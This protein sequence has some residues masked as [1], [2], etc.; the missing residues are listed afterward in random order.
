MMR[1]EW[2]Q[3]ALDEL[4]T[5]WMQSSAAARQAITEATHTADL[6]LEHDPFNEGESRS[7][8]QR[9]TFIPPLAISFRIEEDAQRVTVFHVRLY[10]PRPK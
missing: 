10:R 5:L 6:R 3:A 8:N 2:L 1:V 9:I 4:T 7:G